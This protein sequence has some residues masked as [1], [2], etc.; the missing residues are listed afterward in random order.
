MTSHRLKRSTR[1]AL[2]SAAV[3]VAIG[4][5]PGPAGAQP[6]ADPVKQYEELSG[7]AEKLNDDVL[8][9]QENVEAKKAELDKAG[10]ELNQARQAEEQLRG[11]VDVLTESTFQG[12]RFNGLSAML[13]SDSQQDFLNRMSA[14]EMLAADNAEA[15]DKLSAAVA[16]ANDVQQRAEK[17]ASEATAVADDL[18]KRK[19]DLDGRIVELRK[20]VNNLSSAQKAGLGFGQVKDTGTYLGPPGAANTALQAALSKRGSQYQWGGNGP[21]AFDCSGL[22]KWAYA[23]AGVT[24]PRVAVDQ[25][26]VGRPVAQNELQPG[27]LVFYDDGSGNPATIHHVAMYV[28]E[29]KMVDAPTEGQLV[30]VRPIRGDGHYIGARRIVG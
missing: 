21:N 28:G 22:T 6:A 2:A 18:K 29:G 1:G 13:V 26:R 19:S 9:A 20:A 14:L 25:Y 12:A 15:M 27:D 16:Q 7:Q 17:A 4:S 5:S 23:A 8:K 10:A 3:L 30:D 24:L 11:R